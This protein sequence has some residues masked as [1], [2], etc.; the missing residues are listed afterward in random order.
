MHEA[1]TSTAYGEI[2][3]QSQ[4]S[5]TLPMGKELSGDKGLLH[6]PTHI[7]KIKRRCE[8]EDMGL[9][10][11]KPILPPNLVHSFR[12]YTALHLPLL[13]FFIQW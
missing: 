10:G 13:S 5:V 1:L 3:G 7:H 2:S 9:A 11:I 6:S 12:H 4:A 8:I